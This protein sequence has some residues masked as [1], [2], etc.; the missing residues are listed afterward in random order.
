[1]VLKMIKTNPVNSAFNK[2]YDLI[3]QVPKGKVTTYG[4]IGKKLHMSARVVG[5]ALHANP[6]GSKNPCHRVVNKEGRLAPGFAFGGMSIQKQLLA[7]E[8]VE[9]KDQNHVNLKKHLFNF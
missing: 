6:D 5:F 4:E 8:G 9:F 3:Q 7:Q 2:V 1:M